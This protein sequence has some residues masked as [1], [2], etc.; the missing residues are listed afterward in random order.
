MPHRLSIILLLLCTSAAT[1]QVHEKEH[2]AFMSALL[3]AQ[4]PQA[5]KTTAVKQRVIAECNLRVAGF[6]TGYND[7]IRYYYSNG[8]GSEFDF[9]SANNHYTNTVYHLFAY[10]PM[11][12]SLY[13]PGLPPAEPRVRCDSFYL[14]AADGPTGTMKLLQQTYR[15]Y[16][17][18][19]ALLKADDYYHASWLTDHHYVNV[20][21]AQD[22][23]INTVS[24]K[25]VTQWTDDA[26]KYYF[27]DAAGRLT[28]DSTVNIVLGNAAPAARN[29][30]SYDAGGKLTE[31]LLKNYTSGVWHDVLRYDVSYYPSGQLQRVVTTEFNSGVPSMAFTDSFVYVP[32]IDL[33]AEHHVRRPQ[34]YD[35]VVC[36]FNAQQLPDTIRKETFDQGS[37][38]WVL[39]DKKTFWFNSQ[40]NPVECLIDDIAGQNTIRHRYYYEEYDPQDVDVISTA[41]LKIYPN[42]ATDVLRL[43]WKDA[44]H[45]TPVGISIADMTGRKV[46]SSEQ[47]LDGQGIQINTGVWAS[48][49]YVLT[50]TGKQG[51]R[52]HTQL[53]VKD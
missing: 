18:S 20:Y 9:R 45:Q 5:A 40:N 29:F 52:L 47:T 14:Y 6:F 32:G 53:V 2:K 37:S 11:S 43:E 51:A 17:S 4:T 21:N 8:R 33:Y 10:E 31:A 41:G 23:L 35:R 44:P 3:R 22:R 48:G 15:D 25:Y 19:G 7:S 38:S 13:Y 50:L 30:L 42:P 26:R 16:H 49:V 12:P 27:Y 1:A 36:H 24:R 34:A 39:L 46:F 28:G